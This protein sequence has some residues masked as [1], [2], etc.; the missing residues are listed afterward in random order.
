MSVDKTSV[1]KELE[2]W[3]PVR[4]HVTLKGRIMGVDLIGRGGD[5]SFNW[6]YWRACL[7]IAI[8]FGWQP[9]G[10]IAHPDHDGDWDGGY[11]T[12]DFQEV[13]DS[14]ARALGVALHRAVASVRTGQALTEEQAKALD[15][16]HIGQVCEFADYAVSGG[17]AIY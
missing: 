9:A 16:M 6:S 10:T 11:F 4:R 7:G 15:G 5:V 14:D 13:S 2:R 17:F 3:L 1:E 8:A 12:N